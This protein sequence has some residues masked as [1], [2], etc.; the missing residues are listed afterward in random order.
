M[1]SSQGC[2][3]LKT[4]N[5][6]KVLFAVFLL[7]LSGMATAQTSRK[8]TLVAPAPPNVPVKRFDPPVI[9]KDTLA[10]AGSPVK[11]QPHRVPPPPPPPPP[12]P[13]LIVKSSTKK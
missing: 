13:A 12:H 11:K 5:M 3:S 8:D 6:K 10:V 9:V 2:I 4:C 7:S 1:D